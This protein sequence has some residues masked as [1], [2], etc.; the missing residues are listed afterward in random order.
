[1]VRAEQQ[2]SLVLEIAQVE[3]PLI[4]G[5]PHLDSQSRKALHRGRAFRACLHADGRCGRFK[6]VEIV[7]KA[8]SVDRPAFF[9]ATVRVEHV[10]RM[11]EVGADEMHVQFGFCGEPHV[12]SHHAAGDDARRLD[13]AVIGHTEFLHVRQFAVAWQVG[14]GDGADFGHVSSDCLPSFLGQDVGRRH[15]Y[16]RCGR[17]QHGLLECDQLAQRG[18]DSFAIRPLMVR[19][20]VAIIGVRQYERLRL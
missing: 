6:P 13:D 3:F 19:V 9:R 11:H 5:F 14:A 1:M 4:G 18:D 2:P 16:R 10:V 12:I 17:R 15:I 8:F 7:L 20:F